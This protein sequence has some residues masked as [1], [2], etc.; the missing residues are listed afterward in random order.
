M[1]NHQNN[2]ATNTSYSN[3]YT[4]RDGRQLFVRSPE[5]ED[6]EA[7]V[8]QMKIVDSETKFLAREPDEF[9]LTVEQERDFIK[10]TLSNKSVFFLVGEVDGKIVAN[11]S[12]GL[13][14]NKKRYKHRATL[15]IAVTKDYW[16]LGIGKSL[17][18]EC[19]EWCKREGVEQLELG[20]VAENERA[21]AMYESLGFEI[22]GTKK[23]ALK[24]SDGTYADEHF[25]L[26]LLNE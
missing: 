4:L 10:S 12:V 6:A 20:V 8:D 22:Q 1:C 21:I 9:N 13:V 17:M 16:R 19:I 23:R 15:G 25:M 14:M 7:L 11:C 26:L 18:N 5:V 2:E 24:Y 3:A